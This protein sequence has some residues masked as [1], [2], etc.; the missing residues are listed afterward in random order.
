M[1]ELTLS[2]AAKLAGKSKSTLNR[3]VKSGRLSA[4]RNADGTF[5]IDPS[6]LLRVFPSDAVQNGASRGFE[7][8]RVPVGTGAELLQVNALR[9]DLAKAEQRA[10]VAEA[11][12]DERAR[13][14]DAAERNLSD[15]R[16]LLPMAR[17]A[18][19]ARPWWQF[20]RD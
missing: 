14:L 19:P 15:L 5:S 18:L 13:A 8:F 10:A 11:L 20:W 16:L 6:E 17:A 2:Q 1:P 12:A 7:A 3:A 4:S 9:D